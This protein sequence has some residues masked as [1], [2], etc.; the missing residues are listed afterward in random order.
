MS[1]IQ[2]GFVK[3][4]GQLSYDWQPTAEKT[5]Q[6]SLLSVRA[7]SALSPAASG[8]RQAGHIK[9]LFRLL[10]SQ[11]PAWYFNPISPSS[12]LSEN[13]TS[14]ISRIWKYKR[15]F[16]FFNARLRTQLQLL[17]NVCVHLCACVPSSNT[18][19]S[20]SSGD[21]LWGGWCEIKHPYAKLYTRKLIWEIIKDLKH[22]IKVGYSQPL[23]P[24]P[25]QWVQEKKLEW[26]LTCRGVRDRVSERG[27]TQSF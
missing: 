21:V 2:C 25:V 5:E 16:F 6:L 1:T 14:N 12:H 11:K 23:S 19:T 9:T 20:G 3:C 8:H 22:Q 10:S 27:N 15:F 24:T 4:E 7:Q 17:L 13:F 18:E 26:K